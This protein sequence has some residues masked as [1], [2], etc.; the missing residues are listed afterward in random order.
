MNPL[1]AELRRLYLLDDLPAAA[2]GPGS[3]PGWMDAH[4]QVRAM[5]LEAAQQAGWNSVAA[6]WQGVQDELDLPAPAISV[7]GGGYQV[8]FS[9]REPVAAAQAMD[10][11]DALRRRYLGDVASRHLV[12]WPRADA[13]GKTEPPRTVPAL[14]DTTGRW[15][16]FVAPGLMSMFADEPWLDLPP[17]DE[18]QAKLLAHF[19]SIQPARLMQALDRLQP[20]SAEAAPGA[21]A[22]A[23]EP[24]SHL[25]AYD[26]TDPR[27][28][29]L[30][31]MNDPAIAM[32]LRIE[33]AKA[34]LPF[35]EALR[36]R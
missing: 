21:Q 14:L 29:L 19:E 13:S 22:A 4:G 35:D 25:R 2:Q 5:V 18:A 16:A 8:W 36:R 24:A 27:D 3:V 32:S 11:L 9:L 30:T 12:M 20:P 23:T 26:E 6:L 34:L 1:Q 33:A 17:G 7:S 10:F 31:V 15:S 28:F